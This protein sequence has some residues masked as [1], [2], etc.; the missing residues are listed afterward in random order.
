MNQIFTWIK[1]LFPSFLMALTDQLGCVFFLKSSSRNRPS[2]VS[3][4]HRPRKQNPSLKAPAHGFFALQ[5]WKDSLFLIFSVF[6]AVPFQRGSYWDPGTYAVVAIKL[7]F[8]FLF[9]WLWTQNRVLVCIYEAMVYFLI[10]DCLRTLS[11]FFSQ[12]LFHNDVFL[13]GSPGPLIVA[14]LVETTFLF[15]TVWLVRQFMEKSGRPVLRPGH[16]PVLAVSLLPYLFI[17]GITIWLPVANEELTAETP[18]MMLITLLAGLLLLIGNVT[19]VSSERHTAE[20]HQLEQML[21]VQHAQYSQSKEVADRVN[22]QY[23]DLKNT[24]LYIQNCT[25]QEQ[26]R[27]ELGKMLEQIRPYETEL[28]T[29]NQ[30]VDVILNQKLALCQENHIRCVPYIDGSLLD[31]MDPLDICTILGNALDNAIE[32]CLKIADEQKRQ[33]RIR[34]SL[35][36]QMLSLHVENSCESLPTEKDGQLLTDKPDASAHGF[37]IRSIRHTAEKYGGQ[38]SYRVTEGQFVLDLLLPVSDAKATAV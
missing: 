24:L 18:V 21:F 23:H 19:A 16:I 10:S 27:Q 35:K 20:L 5:N 14:N 13:V 8:Y 36:N 34:I 25:D 6:L 31:F 22:R 3:P 15:L 9:I 17:R 2:S 37:G 29:G 7:C 28:N 32:A 30:A 12:N 33:I 38:L 26:I 1:V 4:F 11:G